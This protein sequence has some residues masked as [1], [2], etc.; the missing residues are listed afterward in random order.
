MVKFCCAA[1]NFTFAREDRFL[2]NVFKLWL[3][4]TVLGCALR[5]RWFSSE[6]FV[7]LQL[8]PQNESSNKQAK[9]RL[10]PSSAEG[11]AAQSHRPFRWPSRKCLLSS[12]DQPRRLINPFPRC[13]AN[14]PNP[15]IKARKNFSDARSSVL[16][17]PRLM[18]RIAHIE[19]CSLRLDGFLGD[20]GCFC[21][22]PVFFFFPARLG[23]LCGSFWSSINNEALLTE[24]AFA[25]LRH[26]HALQL[27]LTG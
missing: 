19:S 7:P 16:S 21:V 15:K 22:L 25:S 9:L 3:A 14:T 5:Q 27:T 26:S 13:I 11:G 2:E 18:G 6:R 4:S 1:F 17:A 24:Y 10:S 23:F 12:S 8:S 20:G